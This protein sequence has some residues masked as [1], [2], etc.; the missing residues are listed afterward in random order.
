M[1]VGE[2]RHL[3]HCST[4]WV[5]NEVLPLHVQADGRNKDDVGRG[6]RD[7]ASG[8][9]HIVMSLRCRDTHKQGI[10]RLLPSN[11]WRP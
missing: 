7:E 5:P 11:R 6:R 10:K 2:D 9:S 3:E 4:M 8:R 1:H